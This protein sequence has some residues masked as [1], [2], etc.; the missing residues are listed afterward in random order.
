MFTELLSSTEGCLWDNEAA[1]GTTAFAMALGNRQAEMVAAILNSSLVEP[2]DDM[3][4]L[5]KDYM[6]VLRIQRANLP[7]TLSRT[8]VRL[9]AP[10]RILRLGKW[11]E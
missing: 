10:V 3:I 11:G 1:D 2:K 4:R 8:Y 9:R 7:H 6:E 5:A